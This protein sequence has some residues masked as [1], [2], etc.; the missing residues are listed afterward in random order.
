MTYLALWEMAIPTIPLDLKERGKAWAG[1][2]KLID[3][4]MQSGLLTS[5]GAF[6]GET[7]GYAIYEGEEVDV[8]FALQRFVPFVSFEVHALASKDQVTKLIKQLMSA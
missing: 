2:M 6:V 5:W 7:N 8:M 3:A 1:L 4:D